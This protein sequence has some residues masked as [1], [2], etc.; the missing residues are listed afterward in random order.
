VARRKV[1]IRFERLFCTAVLCFACFVAG[2]LYTAHF[3][4]VVPKPALETPGAAHRNLDRAS[5]RMREKLRNP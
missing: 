1:T 3:A 5:W 4:F 2:C